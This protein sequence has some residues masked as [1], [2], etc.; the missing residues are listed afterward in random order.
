VATEFAPFVVIVRAIESVSRR[1]VVAFRHMNAS[2]LQVVLSLSGGVCAEQKSVYG[3]GFV[4]WP[5][6]C[7]FS[8]GW[9]YDQG[10]GTRTIP[11]LETIGKSDLASPVRV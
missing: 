1:A 4:R 10:T 5:K 9:K 3:V 11:C 6:Q 8:V 7:I 2:N